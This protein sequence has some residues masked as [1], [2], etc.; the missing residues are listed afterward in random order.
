MFM[1]PAVCGANTW[2]VLSILSVNIQ[3]VI[4][5]SICVKPI[6]VH[7]NILQTCIPHGKT[8]SICL[9]YSKIDKYHAQNWIKRNNLQAIHSFS[10]H[11]AWRP[12]LHVLSMWLYTENS[13]QFPEK[14]NP[15]GQSGD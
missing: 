1:C 6:V 11:G 9:S 13:R 10:M 14:K 15:D 4:H 3:A 7:N 2:T 12:S 5:W 8:K